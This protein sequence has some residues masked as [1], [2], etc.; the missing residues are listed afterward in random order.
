LALSQAESRLNSEVEGTNDKLTA[1]QKTLATQSLIMNATKDA[2]GDFGR[3]SDGLANSQRILTAQMKDLQANM[4]KI[5]L[6]IVESAV[7]F[8]RDFT[9]VLA[10]NQKVMVVVIGVVAALATAIIVANVAMKI[11]TA[12][13]KAAAAAQQL[14]NFVVGKHPIALV[15]IAV[16]AFV[17]ALIVLEKRFGIISKGFELFSDG[18]HRFIINPIKTAIRFISDLIGAFKRI[19]G[20]GAIGGFLG[21][22]N[23]PGL[24]DGGIV[25]RPTLAMVGE[26]GPEAVIP[27][28]RGGG[29][30]GVT[31]NV[32][33]GIST[34]AEIGQAV[35]NSL[36]Q[37]KQIYGPLSAISS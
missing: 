36:L 37:Y 27:L 29:V 33:G 35:Y 10:G 16:A 14:F 13:T 34:S 30:G 24:A 22:I 5:L 26:K 11:Y 4:G 1:Q 25:T 19:P 2:Q 21:G 6:P 3:T 23:I 18:F 31:I 7:S 32:S 28:G 17:A 9:G 8:F 15:I 12:T 20:V